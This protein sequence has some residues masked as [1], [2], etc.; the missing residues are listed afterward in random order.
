MQNQ[1]PGIH[2]GQTA[3]PR[4]VLVTDR[5]IAFVPGGQV[6]DGA[7]SRDP[8]NPDRV[9]VLRPG[10]VMGKITSGGKYAPSFIGAVATAY[11][12]G[13]TSLETSAAAAAE[14]VRRVGAS[15]TFSLV[16]TP[17]NTGDISTDQVT[18]SAVNTTTGV[19]TVTDIGKD[20]VVGSLIRPEDG[21][22][23]PRC[24]I[25]DERDAFGIRVT[26]RDAKDI[27]VPFAQPVV[28]GFL[29]ASQIINYPPTAATTLRQWVKDQLNTRGVF[30][31][32]DDF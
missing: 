10:L 27:D 1:M 21:S 16:S 11:S 9:D 3:T 19:I 8:G 7:E 14:L 31:F 29:D 12:S 5:N 26:D 25:A 2:D 22:E 20:V 15:G 6:I 17:T 28:G 24:I 18:Y 4:K 32:D 23:T 30:L 13:A